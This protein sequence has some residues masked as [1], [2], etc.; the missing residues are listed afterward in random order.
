MILGMNWLEH[1]Y[2]HINCY[3]KSVRF[4]TPEEEENSL[5]SSRQL[6]KLMQEEVHMFLLMASLSVETQAII[7]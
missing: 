2:V 5:L 7:E 1:N 4:S 6:R 3:D